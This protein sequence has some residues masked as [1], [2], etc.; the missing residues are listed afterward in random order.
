MGSGECILTSEL[1]ALSTPIRLEWLL[2]DS[3]YDFVRAHCTCTRQLNRKSESGQS[4]REREGKRISSET[5][6]SAAPTLQQSQ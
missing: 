3:H 5:T 2:F 4:E 1:N 6:P